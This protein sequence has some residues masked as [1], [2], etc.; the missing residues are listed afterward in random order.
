MVAQVEADPDEDA[1]DDA[2]ASMCDVIADADVRGDGAAEI[3]GHQDRA[4]HGRLRNDVEQRRQRVRQLRDAGA[5][6]ASQP[7]FAI[8]FLLSSGM[9]NLMYAAHE[10]H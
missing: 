8:S 4:E 9:L 10:K 5:M 2:G 1:D 6:L 3:A 7:I